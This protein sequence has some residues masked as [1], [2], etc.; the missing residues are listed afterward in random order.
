MKKYFNPVVNT[1][2]IMLGRR[3]N[4]NCRYCMQ[5]NSDQHLETLPTEINE[6]IYDFF[7]NILRSQ[8]EPLTLH[9]YGGEPLVYFNKIKEIVSKT[10]RYKNIKYSIITNGSLITKEISKFLNKYNF[11][12]AVSWDG[13]Q[14]ID[15][16]RKDVFLENKDNIFRCKNLGISAVLSHYAYPMEIL[17]D[18]Q[19]IDNLYRE[20]TGKHLSANIDE[21]FDTDLNDR[22]L[23]DVDYNRVQKEITELTELTLKKMTN[24]LELNSPEEFESKYFIKTT[25]IEHYIN[26]IRFQIKNGINDS[27]I[28]NCKNGYSVLNLDLSGD[29]YS[30]HNCDVKVGN[31]YTNFFKILENV[32]RTDNTK[33]FKETMC[34]DCKAYILC[35]SGCKLISEEARK[36]TYCKLKK[37]VFEPIINGIVS[38]VGEV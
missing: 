35:Q 32:R 8:N 10:Y 15:T 38:F 3:C 34:K 33:Y 27:D 30:C 31:I 28:C 9:F 36:E 17:E 16:R 11:S 37:A 5:L 13:K 25:F 26:S 21:I 6:D 19:E 2:F 23:L 29:L 4:F 24:R 7:R 12:V 1:I 14:S 22:T 20:K 18:I